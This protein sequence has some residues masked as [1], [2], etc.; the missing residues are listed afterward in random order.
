VAGGGWAL[1]RAGPADAAAL[2]RLLRAVRDEC[3]PYL[4]RLHTPADDLW[5]LENRVLADCTVWL[6]ESDRLLGFCAF[7]EGWVDHLYVDPRRH[8]EG[9]G[10]ALLAQAMAAHP[11]LQLWVFQR[12]TAA[13]AFYRARFFRELRLTDGSGNEEREPDALYEWKR[14]PSPASLPLGTLSHEAAGEG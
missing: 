13:I 4:P 3:L 7:R 14:R 6:A 1:R 9:L 10:S 2:A 5:F 11:R 8:R 12:N